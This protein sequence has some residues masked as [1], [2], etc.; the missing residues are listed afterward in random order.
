[1]LTS[2][3]LSWWLLLLGHLP[4]QWLV[5]VAVC[6][7]WGNLVS[8]SCAPLFDRTA[9]ARLRMRHRWTM[10]EFWSGHVLLHVVPLY[11]LRWSKFEWYDGVVAA[12]VH[13]LWTQ[14]VRLDD[15]YVPVAPTVWRSL[16]C[17]AF[18]TEVLVPPLYDMCGNE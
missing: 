11:Y 5:R 3:E 14:R 9:Y 13:L 8:F 4:S 15:V 2:T 16:T 1:M 7:M 17:I 10:L 18:V 6:Y 12:L